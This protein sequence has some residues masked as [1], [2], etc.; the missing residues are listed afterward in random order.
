MSNH[1]TFDATQRVSLDANGRPTAVPPQQRQAK[2]PRPTP[3]RKAAQKRR[4]QQTTLLIL[5][6]AAAIVLLSIIILLLSMLNG[7]DKDDGKILSNVYAAGVNLGGLTPEEAKTKLHDATDNTYGVLDMNVSILDTTIALS[8]DKTGASLDID[9]VVEAAYNYGRTGS[10]AE[11]DRIRQ[12]AQTQ[13]YTISVLEHLNL[14]K[15]YIRN[16]ITEL[17]EQYSTILTQTTYTITGERPSMTQEE[18]DTETVYQVLTI[19]LGTPEYG[20]NI[21]TLYQQVLDAYEINLFQVT[22]RCTMVAPEELDL[23][24]LYKTYCVPY[25]NA[26]INPDTYEVIEEVYGYGFTMEALTEAVEKANYGDPIVLE[27]KFIEPEILSEFYSKEMYQDVLGTFTT[28]VEGS[29]NWIS[30]VKKACEMLNGTIVKIGDTFSFNDLIGEPTEESDFLPA[31]KYV[32]LSHREVIGGGICQVAS[33]LY[34]CALISDLEIVE[35]TGHS[36]VVDYISAGSDAEI[37]YGIFDLKFTNTTENV[38]R[39][40]A[41]VVKDQLTITIMGT[42]T[43]DYTVE[44]RHEI[45][46]TYDPETVIHTMIKDNASGYMDGDLIRPGITGYKISTYLVKFAKPTLD[47]DGKVISSNIKYDEDGIPIPLEEILVGTSYYA[48][49]DRIVVDIYE[50][51]VDPDPTDPDVTDPSEP[52]GPSEPGETEPVEPSGPQPSDRTDPET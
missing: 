39:I 21:N 38:I 42:D 12:Q 4:R 36:Y 52:S 18:Y 13:S 3:S 16:A 50:P 40:D 2:P 33:T 17:G 14:D 31:W 51:P 41:A 32:G 8:P 5:G 11:Q 48:K 24:L 9:A 26:D 19:Q 6:A 46:Q 7:G 30:N 43:R 10:K 28:P 27:M 15:D 29:L 44:I 25:S 22:A 23:E 49:Q 20:L 45:D 34:S 47:E 37:Y 1:D 35:R